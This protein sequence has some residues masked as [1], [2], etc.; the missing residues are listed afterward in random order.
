[1]L[2]SAPAKT[3][4]SRGSGWRLG[5]PRSI[6]VN[7]LFFPVFEIANYLLAWRPPARLLPRGLQP[8]QRTVSTESVGGQSAYLLAPDGTVRPMTNI[9]ADA[10]SPRSEGDVQDPVVYNAV[11]FSEKNVINRHPFPCTKETGF[12]D[13]AGFLYSFHKSKVMHQYC[14]IST[15]VYSGNN[16]S[17]NSPAWLP[18][19]LRRHHRA[20]P[21]R[22]PA[23]VLP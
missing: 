9:L 14:S 11:E 23:R 18:R 12:K 16:S 3:L 5:G 6:E 7:F 8:T 22:L 17:S 19:D 20:L 2:K 4:G 21:F 15:P 10:S 1:M 13:G